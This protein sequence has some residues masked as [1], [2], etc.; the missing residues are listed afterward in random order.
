VSSGIR[1]DAVDHD[2]DLLLAFVNTRDVETGT[3]EIAEPAQLARWAAERASLEIP[4]PSAAEH[5]EALALRESL[6]ALMLA[7]NG[8]ELDEEGLGALRAAAERCRF[9]PVVTAE[10][11]VRLEPGEGGVAALEGKILLAV[12]MVQCLGAWPRLKACTAEDCQ[13]AFYDTTRNRSRT[14]CSM[15]VC[16]NRTKTRRYRERRASR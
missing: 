14:W 2:V 12:E 5:A 11:R 9:G 1:K 10:G 16:G 4:A 8:A 15:D 3:D 6:R 13:W 7:N